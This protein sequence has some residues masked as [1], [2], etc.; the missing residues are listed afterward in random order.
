MGNIKKI[1]IFNEKAFRAF[2]ESTHEQVFGFALKHAKEKKQAEDIVQQ[3]YIQLWEKRETIEPFEL[4]YKAY[5]FTI[6][7]N[8]IIKEY[9]RIL[10]EQEILHVFHQTMDTSESRIDETVKVLLS[11]IKNKVSDLPKRQR[12]VFQLV[13][14]N[15]M[16]YKEAAKI[17]EISESTVEKHISQALNT[18]KQ[19]LSKFAYLIL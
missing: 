14:Y 5:L 9:K 19:Q 11:E 8:L 16:T 7:R 2:F 15:G 6:V 4:K 3:A 10:A 12:Q 18:L 13:K 1:S 17:L